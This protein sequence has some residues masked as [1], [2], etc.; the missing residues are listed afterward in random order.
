MNKNQGHQISYASPVFL[1]HFKVKIVL[2]FRTY[3]V[4]AAGNKKNKQT[5]KKYQN[6]PYKCKISMESMTVVPNFFTLH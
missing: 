5:N 1:K 6:K 3:A 2:E 4:I